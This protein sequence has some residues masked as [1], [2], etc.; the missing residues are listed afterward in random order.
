MTTQGNTTH[1]Q[2]NRL[3]AYLHT[4][5]IDTVTARKE[6]DILMPA[7]RVFELRQQGYDIST[8]R[9]DRVTDAGISHRVALYVLMIGA[10]ATAPGNTSI[11][12]HENKTDTDQDSMGDR[13]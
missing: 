8:V 6:L 2:R 3:L 11:G 1:A 13:L 4:K 9:V 5:P 10:A 7:A 12:V